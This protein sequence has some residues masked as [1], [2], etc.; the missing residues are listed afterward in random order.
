M[1]TE[2]TYRVEWPE[3]SAA[4]AGAAA[5][6]AARAILTIDRVM[7]AVVGMS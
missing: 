1:V 2:S 6:A 5:E 7:V 3:P 4:R